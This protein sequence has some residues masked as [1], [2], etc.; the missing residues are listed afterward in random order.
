MFP[1]GQAHLSSSHVVDTILPPGK[2]SYAKGIIAEAARWRNGDVQTPSDSDESYG[3]GS[4]AQRSAE[5]SFDE[6]DLILVGAYYCS[7]Q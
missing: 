7:L 4:E 6:N 5:V 3:I 1:L 2:R